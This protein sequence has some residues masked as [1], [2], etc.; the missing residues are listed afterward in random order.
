MPSTEKMIESLFERDPR[1]CVAAALEAA[2]HVSGV[3]PDAFGS[4]PTLREALAE[5]QKALLSGS[6]PNSSIEASIMFRAT[7]GN[8]AAAAARDS[9]VAALGALYALL[10]PEIHPK[11]VILSGTLYAFRHAKS[12]LPGEAAWQRKL[13]EDYLAQ[14]R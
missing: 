8:H 13:I 3:W 5:G 4:N 6:L 9:A 14:T 11:G 2:A 1:R 10:H 12:A 7:G